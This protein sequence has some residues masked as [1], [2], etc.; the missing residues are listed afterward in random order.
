VITIVNVVDWSNR[1]YDIKMGTGGQR[2]FDNDNAIIYNKKKYYFSTPARSISVGERTIQ[3]YALNP[4][5]W[6]II[7]YK[8]PLTMSERRV[9]NIHSQAIELKYTYVV[10]TTEFKR[11][12]GGVTQKQLS[13]ERRESRKR[14]LDPTLPSFMKGHIMINVIGAYDFLPDQNFFFAII[15]ITEISKYDKISS[16]VI[17]ALRR[18]A[19]M[20]IFGQ[21]KKPNGREPAYSMV[22]GVEDDHIKIM[23]QNAK[24]GKSKHLFARYDPAKNEFYEVTI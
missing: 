3:E 2:A 12:N 24:I 6:I 10:Y 13:E 7:K 4:D 1:E 11:R 22:E 15:P 19:S 23:Y 20:R 14:V 21:P 8:V 9:S 17:Y 5:N 16:K 18:F